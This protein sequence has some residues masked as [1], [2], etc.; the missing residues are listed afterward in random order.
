MQGMRVRQM[1]FPG[2]QKGEWCGTI[3]WAMVPSE[4]ED[5]QLL[6]FPQIPIHS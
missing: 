6:S 4:M 3:A 5:L 2:S 1:C